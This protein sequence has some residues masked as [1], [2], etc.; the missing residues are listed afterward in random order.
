MGL[1][2]YKVTLIL[3]HIPLKYENI[4]FINLT[5]KFKQISLIMFSHYY[6]YSL[7][8]YVYFLSIYCEKVVKDENHWYI[9]IY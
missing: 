1:L 7:R 2:K 9:A 3:K 5:N 6:Y 4:T 8:Y